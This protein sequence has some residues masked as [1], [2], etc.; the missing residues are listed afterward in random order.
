MITEVEFEANDEY[1]SINMKKGVIG[2]LQ[3]NLRPQNGQSYSHESR[4][5]RLRSP[6]VSSSYSDA[7]VNSVYLVMEVRRFVILSALD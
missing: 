4:V 5:N 6:F 7:H 3:V 2:L 1:W